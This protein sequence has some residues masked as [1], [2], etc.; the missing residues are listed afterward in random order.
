MS[1]I[2]TD[3]VAIDVDAGG[4]KEAVIGL[5][6]SRL[7]DAGRSS[8]RDGLVGGRHGTRSAVGHG[9]S[10]RH[11]DPALPLPLRRRGHHR[12]RPVVACGR[13]RRP[14]RPGGPRVPDR[15]AGLR[16]CRAHE[17]AVQPRTG[18]GAQGVRRIAAQ[19]RDGRR[20]GRT[21]RRRGQS[22]AR[23]CGRSDGGG[24]RCPRSRRRRGPGEEQDADRH[25]GLPHRNRPHLHGRRLAGA[26]REGSGRDDARRDAGLLGQ[27]SR[28]AR[29]HRERRRRHLRHR[30]RRQG[31]GSLRGQARHRIRSQAGHQR[32]RQDGRRSR[33]RSG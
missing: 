33:C 4:D 24:S 15:R 26:G 9:S 30:R 16:R 25:H 3:L 11:R 19:R 2:T 27:H 23:R 13:L 28:V 14:R 17:A 21:G 31:Q 22:R 8:D 32:A 5:L 1:I 29:G 10:R 12:V 7:A 6:A 20:G 18:I